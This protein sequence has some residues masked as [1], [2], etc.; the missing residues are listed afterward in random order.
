[1]RACAIL[2]TVFAVVAALAGT[3]SATGPISPKLE[4][5]LLFA[6]PDDF[7]PVVAMMEAFPTREGLMAEVRDL[8]RE[9]RRAH[10][11]STL[12]DLADRSQQSLR[13]VLAEES[14]EIREVHMLWGINGV[15]FEAT[16]RV[17]ERLSTLP[18]IR[19]LEQGRWT[20][21]RWRP[22][23]DPRPH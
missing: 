23:H 1:M 11:V 16:P 6:A 4:E 18:G 15:A 22:L 17:V 10:V 21:T 13:A 8:D 9:S 12:K 19:A 7:V 2:V 5:A 20:A 14:D 3:P